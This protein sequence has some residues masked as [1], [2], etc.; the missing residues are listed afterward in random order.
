MHF[1]ISYSRL[2]Y[3]VGKETVANHSPLYVDFMTLRSGQ[4]VTVH[5][6]TLYHWFELG[7]RLLTVNFY[8]CIPNGLGFFG[9][10]DK[11]F[12]EYNHR[13]QDCLEA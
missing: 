4:N 1:V 2:S 9:V 6:T 13:R 5:S 12:L 10:E 3:S 7:R 8:H 11:R